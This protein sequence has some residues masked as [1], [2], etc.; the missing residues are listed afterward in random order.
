MAAGAGFACADADAW[1]LRWCAWALWCALEDAC[2]WRWLFLCEWWV[3]GCVAPA[4]TGSALAARVTPSEST[5]AAANAIQDLGMRS[6][7]SISF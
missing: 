2:A 6:P 7:L 1:V 4:A 5:R 3:E